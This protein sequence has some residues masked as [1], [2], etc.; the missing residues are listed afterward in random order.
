M[1][2]LIVHFPTFQSMFS[3]RAELART[4]ISS[5]SLFIHLLR[6]GSFGNVSLLL[7]QQ[8]A[9]VKINVYGHLLV[10]FSL[11]LALL[12]LLFRETSNCADEL[13]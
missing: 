7:P 13:I 3:E 5:D 8:A 9:R 11:S 2:S 1:L 12:F 10:R 4:I 6:L